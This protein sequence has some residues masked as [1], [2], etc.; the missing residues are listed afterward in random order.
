MKNK[1]DTRKYGI[2]IPIKFLDIPSLSKNHLTNLWQDPNKEKI[3]FLS[4]KFISCIIASVSFFE[5]L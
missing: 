2:Y 3:N 5:T 4:E 1:M